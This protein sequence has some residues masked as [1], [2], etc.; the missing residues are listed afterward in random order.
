MTAEHTDPDAIPDGAPDIDARIRDLP[1]RA[2]APS[3]ATD[4]PVDADAGM[5]AA[6]L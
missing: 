4:G 3:G 1:V 5:P 6:V 2:E